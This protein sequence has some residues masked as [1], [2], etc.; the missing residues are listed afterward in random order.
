MSSLQAQVG[1]FEESLDGL[2]K[3][4][5]AA[6]RAMVEVRPELTADPPRPLGP[7]AQE[8]QA[9]KK[10]K[11]ANRPLDAPT[12]LSWHDEVQ[13]YYAQS[14]RPAEPS[15]IRSIFAQHQG[16]YTP[17]RQPLPLEQMIALRL[18]P[19]QWH[20]VFHQAAK[21]RDREERQG[22]ADQTPPPYNLFLSLAQNQVKVRT[23][24]EFKRQR[25]AALRQAAR[26]Q[27]PL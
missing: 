17:T 12:A 6:W 14:P 16:R 21:I 4:A 1:D 8:R 24:I 25:L 23:S 20:D 27:E 15:E 19:L 13:R 2:I 18:S 11:E 10:R 3:A 7:T 5:K 26:A 9:Q 22:R